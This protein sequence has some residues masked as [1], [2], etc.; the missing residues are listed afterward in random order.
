MS[1]NWEL[2]DWP[3]FHYHSDRIS[4]QERQFLLGVG[5]ACAFLKN[6]GEQEYNQFV[7]EILSLEG[8]ESSRIEGEILDRESLQSSIKQHFGLNTTRKQEAD[9]ESRM[10]T[11]LCNVYESFDRPLTHEMLWQWH[12]ML[13]DDQSSI[14]DCGKYRT[15]H[16]PMQ[17]VSHRYDAPK[18]F[19]EAPPSVK[20]PD[21]MA[22]FVDWFNSATTS[23]PILGRAAIAHIYFESIHPFE[24]GNGRIGRVLVEKV[25]SKGVERPILIA[26][27]KVLEKREKEYYASL[28]RCNRTLEVDHWVEFFAEVVLQAQELS[29]SL[30]Y[31][32]I[33][34]SK[35]L[36]TLSGQLN[37][38]Q[39]KVLLR[40]FAE[41]PSGFRGGLSAENYIAITKTSRATATRDLIDLIQKGALLKTGELRHTRYWL[42]LT[43]IQ[44][45]P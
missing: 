24:D 18:V 14:A 10:A 30:L 17:I 15:H 32:L 37:P 20:I 21:E 25:L 9:K 39:E 29:M 45:L 22:T 3:Q 23:E 43:T 13:F 7:V 38:R 2:P 36:T 26:V 8:T 6:I 27:S 11:V 31:F 19:F 1:W 33:E 40:M 16:E 44:K 12:A 5:S 42:N 35:M 28:E 41:G 4:Q 34:K